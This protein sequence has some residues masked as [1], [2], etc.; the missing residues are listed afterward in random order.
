MKNVQHFF[1]KPVNLKMLW[2]ENLHFL[3]YEKNKEILQQ[4]EQ[5]LLEGCSWSPINAFAYL[6]NQRSSIMF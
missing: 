5:I 1:F 4:L 6:E 3:T 2:K